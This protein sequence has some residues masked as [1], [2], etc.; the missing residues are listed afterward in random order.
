M[1]GT[2]CI[3]DMNVSYKE[4]ETETDLMVEKKNTCFST[5]SF[6]GKRRISLTLRALGSLASTENFAI[7]LHQNRTWVI[8]I[9]NN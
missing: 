1:S 4:E 5:S 3:I 7:I 8:N 2:F 6:F 9:M